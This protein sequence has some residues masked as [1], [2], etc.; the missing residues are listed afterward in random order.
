MED[1][2]REEGYLASL[3]GKTCKR[4][5]EPHFLEELHSNLR[6]KALQGSRSHHLLARLINLTIRVLTKTR[7]PLLNHS[8]VEQV[9]LGQEEQLQAIL[10][11]C[12][13]NQ[14]RLLEDQVLLLRHQF[15]VKKQRL[16]HNQL[17]VVSPGL[18]RPLLL[19]VSSEDQNLQMQ[20]P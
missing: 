16:P 10:V 20:I 2:L 5:K 9:F 11:V 18:V 4:L 13:T 8:V 7:Q 15:L 12:L 6:L 17:Q 14:P 1:Q 19:Q 3:L